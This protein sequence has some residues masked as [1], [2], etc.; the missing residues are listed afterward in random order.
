VLEKRAGRGECDLLSLVH[1]LTNSTSFVAS[2]A[3]WRALSKI[4]TE[5]P[6]G[7]GKVAGC[8]LG[9]VAVGD[10]P[11]L[12]KTECFRWIEPAAE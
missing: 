10:V 1:V 2:M 8:E 7:V 9:S 12:E 4:Q 6:L 3:F 11:G 5:Y